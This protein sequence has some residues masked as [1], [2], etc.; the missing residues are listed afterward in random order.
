MSANNISEFK[1]SNDEIMQ[2]LPSEI[3]LVLVHEVFEDL[4]GNEVKILENR[5]LAG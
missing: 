1:M 5:G 4:R 3:N 2:N